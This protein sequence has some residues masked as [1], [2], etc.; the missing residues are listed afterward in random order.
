MNQN[1]FFFK[2]RTV[3]FS[4]KNKI[5][6]EIDRLVKDG[7]LKPVQYSKYA[8]P[9]VPVLKANGDVRICGDF[10]VSINKQL[11]TERYP[12]PKVEELFSNLHGGEEFSKLDLSSAYLQL[13]L[14]EESQP[15]TCVNTHKGLFQYTRLIYG[16]SCA[17]ALFQKTIDSIVTGIEGVLVFQD[18]ILVT[19]ANKN[20]HMAR[21]TQVLEKL[22]DAG[23]VLQKQKCQFFEK[24]VSYL[25]YVIDKTGLHKSPEKVQAIV[26]ASAPTNASELKS[27]LGLINYYRIF[28]P[29]ASTVLSPLYEL[30]RKEV[31][32]HWNER[33]E[34]TFNEIKKVLVSEC[35]LAHFD[36][37]A[38]LVLTVDA[39]PTG[40]GA[41]LAQ[42]ENGK[43]RPISFASRVLSKAER[44]YSQIQKEATAI[45]FGIRRYHQ[46]LYGRSEP[47]VLRTDHDHKPLLSI[48]NPGKGVP[49]V[50]ANR[51]QRYAIFLS[52][53][54]YTIQYVSSQENCA[55]FFSRSHS[56][57]T[58]GANGTVQ[59]A[60][61]Q[62]DDGNKE[63]ES[64]S[65]DLACYV[66]FITSGDL[67][68]TLDTV[69]KETLRD[70]VLQKVLLFLKTGWPR[71]CND[72]EVSPYWKCRS[73]F[74]H[75]N[76]C[77][78]RGHR[79]VVPKTLRERVLSELHNSH[80]GICKTKQ[81][82]RSRFWWPNVD[83]EIESFIGNCEICI[84]LRPA[85]PRAP[86]TPW[87]FPSHPWER[88][89]IDLLGPIHGITCLVVID[90][91]TKW[92]ECF[93]M[94]H[95]YSS[96]AIIDK[97]IEVISRFGIMKTIVSDNGTYFISDEFKQFF[98]H[99]TCYI[100]DLLPGQ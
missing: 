4:L 44:N 89:H 66:N 36:S 80:L 86:L 84:Q 12:L 38:Q 77:L 43:E 52:A 27:F 48:F 60:A 67:P 94:Q 96:A 25:G 46:F 90:A 64:S 35:V 53:Y 7:V 41:I 13:P 1:H 17:P 55:D 11:E 39:S 98:R 15:L 18:D 3:P 34:A 97:L 40:L 69:R 79:L 82:A 63:D 51:L 14:S 5:E 74:S 2:A 8:S 95:S 45:I 16:L 49:E 58:V 29:N 75:E 93:E 72:N 22:Q 57:N 88:V 33:H 26:D 65:V 73:Q 87:P 78:L 68:L 24:S 85:P 42:I 92:V 37:K 91:Y 10:S 76:G 20:E 28:I 30:L 59:S 47:F 62:F 32:W 9:I 70:Q 19:G 100:A 31:K 61:G 21:L 83:R 50:S 71:K 54:N 23:L 56:I 6:A 81:E 99:F